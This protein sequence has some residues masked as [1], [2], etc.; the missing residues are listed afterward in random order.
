[1]SEPTK[2]SRRME[3]LLDDEDH[4]LLSLLTRHEKLSKA[5]I[6][7]RALRAYAKKALRSSLTEVQSKVA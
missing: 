1:M 2:N 7:R 4:H 3:L 6:L 5:N